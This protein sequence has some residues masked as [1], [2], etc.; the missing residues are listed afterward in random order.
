M[1]ATHR[2]IVIHSCAKQYDYVKGQK[3]CGPN[4]E[5]CHKTYRFDL[6][7]KGQRQ[8]RIMNVRDTFSY[9]ERPMCQ[10]W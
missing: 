5:A 1:Y 7:V 4:T 10:I 8:I 2:T 3:R 6:E 9:G